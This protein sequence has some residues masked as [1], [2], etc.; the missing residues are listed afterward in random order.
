M[1]AA[2][3]P[4]SATTSVWTRLVCGVLVLFGWAASV[5]GAQAAQ[6]TAPGWAFSVNGT[7]VLLDRCLV[8]PNSVSCPGQNATWY[9]NS[10]RSEALPS[11]LTVNIAV[12]GSVYLSA[13][14]QLMSARGGANGQF[15]SNGIVSSTGVQLATADAGC[16]YGTLCTSRGTVTVSFSRAVT[17]PVVS[18]TGLGG[19]ASNGTLNGS[20]TVSW[21]ELTLTTP[22]VTA[23]KL[24]GANLT[25]AANRIEPTTKNPTASCSTTS[26][27][28]YG[29]TASAACGS[30]RLTGS[31]TSFTFSADLGSVCNAAC[32]TGPNDI[33]DGWTMVVSVDE[34]FGLAPA[35]YDTTATSHVVG[36]LYMGASV[37][38]DQTGTMNPATNVDAFAAGADI[39]TI[40]DG[41]TAFA[42]SISFT[43]GGTFSAP[44]ALT[45]VDAAAILCGWID[46]DASG[47][48]DSATER[49]CASPV[50]G[51]TS[52][53]LTWNVPATVSSSVK[54]ARL[55]LSFDSAAN[56]PVGKVGSGEVEDYSFAATVAAT[57]T[58]STSTTTSNAL[59]VSSTSVA[60][61]TTVAAATSMSN[62]TTSS[63]TFRKVSRSSTKT[64]TT[65]VGQSGLP[66]T[67]GRPAGG[68]VLGFALIALG[69]VIMIRRRLA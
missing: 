12:T 14:D 41:T 28:S 64:T 10:T 67:G 53:T 49:V 22:G 50:S 11:G 60:S 47:T 54:Y 35:S 4:R 20:K 24:A 2:K 16:T 7:S 59:V 45:G 37:V 51:D 38:A 18:V 68:L 32:Y 36:P 1:P 27:S 25:V 39:T 21:T 33:E 48:F 19:G 56:S 29:A 8:N 5:D 55:R 3:L 57:T 61:T 6:S 13:T 58:S 40:D 62:T 26:D 17:N 44:V 42:G 9:S 43:P 31:G 52:A 30:I 46:F 15:I 63:T 69:S 66:S 34:D 65:A 23:D